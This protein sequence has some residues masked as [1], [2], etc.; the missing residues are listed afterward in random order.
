MDPLLNVGAAAPGWSHP[1]DNAPWQ[2]ASRLQARSTRTAIVP[3]PGTGAQGKAF[4][5]LQAS[6]RSPASSWTKDGRGASSFSSW[7][8]HR[9]LD[10][11]T[12]VEAFARQVGVPR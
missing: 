5:T 2:G 1:S 11:L 4:S 10:S 9:D 7:G 3:A 12:A 6:S 8:R